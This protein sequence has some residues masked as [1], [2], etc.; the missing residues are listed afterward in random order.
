[1][2]V[3]KIRCEK[4]VAWIPNE[5]LTSVVGNCDKG[6]FVIKR[7]FTFKGTFTDTGDF[8]IE[9]A[10]NILVPGAEV[11]VTQLVCSRCGRGVKDIEIDETELLHT[12][13]SREVDM[14]RRARKDEREGENP[15][16]APPP[17]PGA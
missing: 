13:R 14:L 11:A 2:K 6:H 3:R 8:L 9:G 15:A 7:E 17:V 5:F 10:E 16:G 12:L 4:S 1:M